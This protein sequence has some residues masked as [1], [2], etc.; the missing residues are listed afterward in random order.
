MWRPLV[1]SYG[2]NL[3]FFSV[4]IQDFHQLVGAE[5]SAIWV[6]SYFEIG[7]SVAGVAESGVFTLSR[8]LIPQ[9]VIT[10]G[11]NIWFGF[12]WGDC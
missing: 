8:L 3:K 6:G 2:I 11:G 4:M 5:F 7:K 1:D 12:W 10:T 9:P